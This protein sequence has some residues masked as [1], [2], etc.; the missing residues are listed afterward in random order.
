[1]LGIALLLFQSA[2]GIMPTN[3]TAV[4]LKEG[5]TNTVPW[6]SW[7]PQERSLFR[8][9]VTGA[10]VAGDVIRTS[11]RGVTSTWQVVGASN[12]VTTVRRE[13]TLAEPSAAGKTDPRGGVP[14]KNGR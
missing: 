3:S 10:V 4:V 5:V 7:T 13:T 1:M 14:A 9:N 11:Q 12:G 6:S 2:H 8:W